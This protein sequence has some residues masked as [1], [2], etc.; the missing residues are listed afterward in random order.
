M[1]GVNNGTTYY[2]K[3]TAVWPDSVES[4][5]S[6]EASATP[7]N[8]NPL[9]PF[10]LTGSVNARIVSLQWSFYDSLGDFDHFAMYKKLI[11]GGT[12]TQAGTTTDSSGTITIPNGEDGT[13][14]FAVTAVDDGTPP[15]ESERSNSVTLPVGHL[16]P[17]NLRAT[18]D[19]ES[20][21]PLSWSEPGLRPTTTLMYD[22]GIL[23]NAYYYYDYANLMAEQ[24]TA[25]A[26]VELDTIWIHVLTDGDAYWP[27]PDGTH[28]PI[29]VSVY[30]D[31]G[32]GYPGDQIFYQEATGEPGEWIVIGIDGG[33][34]IPTSN[35]WIAMGNLA[36]GGEEG[37]GVDQFSDFPQY[38][39][40]LFSGSWIQQ[41][42]YAGD[43]MIRATIV[44]NGRSIL[45][46][47]KAPTEELALNK[48]PIPFGKASGAAPMLSTHG[49]PVAASGTGGDL[50]RPL[51][52]ETL[53]GYAIYRST[54]ANVPVD[55]AHRIRAYQA[56]GLSRTYVDSAVTNGTTYYYV[57]TAVYDENSVIYESP[58]SN[59]VVA[60]PRVG[61]RMV[62][63]PLSYNVTGQPGRIITRNL[64]IS[65]PG[66]LNLNFNINAQS[67]RLLLDNPH[68]NNGFVDAMHSYREP[69]DKSSIRPDDPVNP[70]MLLDSGG[71]DEFGYRWIDSDEPGG[72]AFGWAEITDR[73]SSIYM[74]DDDNQGPFDLGFD[75]SFY[76]N[77]YSS[78]NI[79][80][81]GWISFTSVSLTYSNMYIP[82]P[83]APLDLVAPFWDDMYPP[84]GGEIWY[85][86]TGDSF[87]V[88]Y[89]NIPHFGG[90]GPYTYQVVLTS[91]GAISYNYMD[92]FDQLNSATIGIQNNDGS[93]GLLVAYDQDYIHSM[94]S[95]RITAGWLSADPA[96]GVV[97]PSGNNNINIVFDAS[98]LDPG[99]YNGS[100]LVTGWD[101]NHQVGQVTIPVTFHV[102]PSSV[103]DQ[104]ADLPKEFGLAQNYPNPFNPTTEILFTLPVNSH[105]NLD[106]YNIMG[107]KVRTLVN[108]DMDAGYKSVTW[109]GTDA[110]GSSVASGTYFYVLKAGDKVF[111]KKM[112][113]LK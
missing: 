98:F 42:L 56:Q 63:D 93:I 74:N 34:E 71:P 80:S 12:W 33:L 69:V 86:S 36:G 59:E 44:D 68:Q 107:Q 55:P 83:N 94:M 64:N 39:W 62:L 99:I 45:L 109:N 72:P 85:Y 67:S 96:S 84:G 111:T 113:M 21:V 102:D 57:V 92:M 28:D 95:I 97:V 53:V 82:D 19:Q 108:S 37:I 11:P 41:D 7:A 22:D 31:D 1:N 18:T 51:D 27:W 77:L 48:G 91:N 26:P 3:L 4:P 101:A 43:H 30:S 24:F 17:N 25:T 89:I 20:R 66:G 70:P 58:A 15:L 35:F 10:N 14:A 29:G 75:F 105:V 40:N 100:L 8:H 54:S 106:I 73:G 60:T 81:N 90:G 104:V 50:P 38:K 9:A 110:N 88:S 52:T 79:C 16:P 49:A 2:Y 112:T 23:A 103:D 76:G 87:I 47:E 65:N 13:Y 5:A 46:S 61:G 32:S 78:V 6:N